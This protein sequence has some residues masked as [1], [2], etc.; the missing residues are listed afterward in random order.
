MR[1]GMILTVLFLSGLAMLSAEPWKISGDVNLTV[2]QSAYSDNWAG[3]ELGGIAWTSNANFAAEKQLS[4]LLH[5]KSSLKLAFG[6]THQQV[7]ASTG[8][9]I[10]SRPVKSTDK[11]DL[12]SMLKLT[13]NILVDPFV[14]ARWESQFIEQV[15]GEKSIALNPSLFTET[16]GL[17]KMILAQETLSLSA[18]LGAAFRQRYQRDVKDEFGEYKDITT[19]DGGAEFVSEFLKTIP[20]RDVKLTS[21]L[22]LY[23]AL[24]NSK[25]DELPNDYWK[26]LDVKWNNTLTTKIWGALNFNLAFDLIY[27]K[28]QDLAGQ[29]KQTLGLG[30]SYNLF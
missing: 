22:E 19:N 2:N 4:R 5:S 27:E 28:E 13:A 24:F 15:P 10:W 6:Q 7:T 16:A 18:R 23:Q 12:E 14:S 3:S 26:A 1:T 30:V 9:K 17:S 25:E 20:E 29:F 21:R 11:I 8:E